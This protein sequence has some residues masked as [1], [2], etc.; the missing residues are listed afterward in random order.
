MGAYNYAI[1]SQEQQTSAIKKRKKRQTPS[2]CSTCLLNWSPLDDGKCYI[3][4]NN[5][6]P[7]PWQDA[8]NWCTSEGGNLASIHSQSQMDYIDG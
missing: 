2:P 1:K 6:Q 4:V 8:Q 7:M 3:L 5:E